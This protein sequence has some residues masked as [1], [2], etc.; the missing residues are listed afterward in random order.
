RETDAGL[1]ENVYLLKI[2][3]MSETEQSYTLMVRGIE[4]ADLLLD[5]EAIRVASGEVLELP[6]SVRADEANLNARSMSIEFVLSATRDRE[7][8]AIEEARFLGPAR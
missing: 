8:V 5:R 6:V 3:N 1:V 2:L 4:G 7:L